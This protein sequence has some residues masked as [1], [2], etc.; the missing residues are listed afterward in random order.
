[1]TFLDAYNN[2]ANPNLNQL[3]NGHDLITRIAGIFRHRFKKQISDKGLRECFSQ[4]FTENEAKRTELFKSLEKWCKEN[5][6]NILR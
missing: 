5:K 2:H 4:N 3:T 6:V 1:M